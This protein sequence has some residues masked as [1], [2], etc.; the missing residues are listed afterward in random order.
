MKY[1]QHLYSLFYAHLLLS[2][3]L[4]CSAGCVS[5]AAVTSAPGRLAL[6]HKLKDNTDTLYTFYFVI[7]LTPGKSA[8]RSK[9]KSKRHRTAQDTDGLAIAKRLTPVNGAKLMRPRCRSVFTRRRPEALRPAL[10]VQFA[11]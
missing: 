11:F 1:Y 9:I 5:S 7:T 3:H 6:N 2:C 4:A 10:S 8:W